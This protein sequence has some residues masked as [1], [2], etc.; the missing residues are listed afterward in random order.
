MIYD[1]HDERIPYHKL[2]LERDNMDGIPDYPL[3]AG[4]RFVFYRP[5]DHCAWIE[6]EKSAKEFDSY[7][8]G[9]QI[10]ERFYGGKD[11]ELIHRMVFIENETGEKVATASAYYDIH[12]NDK[13]GAGW[14]HWV[15][16]KRE[17]QGKGL[18]RP[19]ISHTLHL[20]RRLG[21]SHV[22]IQTQSISW[23]ACRLYMDFGFSPTAQ[24]A[25]DNIFGW[26]IIKRLT[27]HPILSD[28]EPA[29]DEEMQK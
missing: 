22:I 18:A 15:A 16:V 26:R 3:P 11:H 23:V 27:D 24:S 14:L 8:R 12:G 1:N 9:L 20:L 28:F 13:T 5:G 19:L 4:Y 2:F 10:W 7:E 29:T 25:I 17:Y 6:I 21:Y